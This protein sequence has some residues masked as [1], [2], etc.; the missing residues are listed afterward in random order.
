REVCHSFLLTQDLPNEPILLTEKTTVTLSNIEVSEKLFFV[1]LEKTKVTIGE[2]VSITKH[3]DSE[4]CIREHGMAREI[5]VWLEGHN[6]LSSL[7]LENIERM[8]P[9][10][11]GC[12]LKEARLYSI[13]LINIV[14]KLR[15]NEVEWLLVVATEKE[16]VAT[17]LAQDQPFCVGYVET[18]TLKDY[19]VSI[20]LK[21]RIR[22]DCCEV[23]LLTLGA[24]KKEHVSEILSQEKPV[25]IG[26]VETMTLKNYAVSILLKLRIHK[27]CCEVKLL[28]LGATKKEHVAEILSQEKPV[29]IGRVKEMVLAKYAVSVLPKLRINNDNTM[30]KFVLS[31]DEWHF[32]RILEEKDKSIEVG[33]IRRG[34]F[35]VPEGIRRKLRYDLVDEETSGEATAVGDGEVEEAV[36]GERKMLEERSSSQRGSH[37]D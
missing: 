4:N 37:L 26:R 27:D 31:A 34:G 32:S 6:A 16:D 10:S 30:E 1:L 36:D 28:T 9:S 18:M 14:P 17:I 33:R 7:A 13:G 29:F 21:L 24:T 25:F 23:K 15:I 5:P 22:K 19:A 3:V 2:R 11:I 20:L 12:S 35:D 8:P